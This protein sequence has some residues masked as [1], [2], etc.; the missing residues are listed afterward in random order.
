MVQLLPS[1][2]M[3]AYM[4]LSASKAVWM[5]V[6]IQRFLSISDPHRIVIPVKDGLALSM[7]LC[8]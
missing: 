1:T 2:E 7:N 4:M 3:V 6:Q 8:F 5:L